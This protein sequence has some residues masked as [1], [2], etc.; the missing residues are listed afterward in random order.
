MTPC[1]CRNGIGPAC[2]G[3]DGE[4]EGERRKRDKLAMLEAQREVFVNR[5]RRALLGRLLAAGTATA[6]DVMAA[7]TLPAEIDPRC[8]GAV[9]GPLAKA[10]IICFVEFVKSNRP[11]RHGSYIQLWAL[12]DRDEAL[13]WLAGHPDMPDPAPEHDHVVGNLFGPDTLQEQRPA[14]VTVGR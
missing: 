10:G 6:D 14:A 8:F 5:G 2:T 9:P 4:R 1:N 12:V 13:L 11:Q 7:V 3:C